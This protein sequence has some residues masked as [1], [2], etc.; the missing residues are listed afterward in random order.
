VDLAGLGGAAALLTPLDAGHWS[1][2]PPGGRPHLD[3]PRTTPDPCLQSTPERPCECVGDGRRAGHKGS[4]GRVRS[5]PSEV[6]SEGLAPLG[7]LRRFATGR[8]NRS[9]SRPPARSRAPEP[10]QQRSPR[11]PVG[12]RR[13]CP[14]STRGCRTRGRRM[15]CR[16]R[17][18]SRYRSQL[19]RLSTGTELTSPRMRAMAG[20]PTAPMYTANPATHAAA[21]RTITTTRIVRRSAR[22]TTIGCQAAADRSTRHQAHGNAKRPSGTRW[23]SVSIQRLPSGRLHLN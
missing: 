7:S 20:F 1:E 8:H 19:R 17:Q 3:T 13:R 2:A 15:S 9:K 10:A 23:P 5:D 22:R 14:S 6:G 18:G 16:R 21:P 4:G 12:D 11:R